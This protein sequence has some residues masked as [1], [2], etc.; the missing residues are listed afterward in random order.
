[1]KRVV[2]VSIG[3][4]KRN[5][6]VKTNMFGEE[7]II[8]R[9][10]T[11][12]DKEKAINLIKEL[13]G[14]VD[15]FG[16]GGIDIYLVCKDKKY[17][18][19]DSTPLKEAAVKTPIVDGSSLKNTLERRVIEY[20]NKNN[21]V[22]LKNA[23]IL[24]TSALDRFGMA[25]AFEKVGSIVTYGDVMFTLGIPVKIKSYNTLYNIAKILAPIATKLPFEMLYPTGK[26]QEVIKE[27]KFEK[28]YQEADIIAGDFLY[29]NRYMPSDMKGK[30][31]ITNTVTANDIQEMKRKGVKLLITTTPEFEGR[32]FGT[33]VMEATIVALLGKYPEELTDKEYNRALDMFDFRPRIEYLNEEEQVL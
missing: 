5:H 27:D 21:I 17:I 14:K 31:I 8:E 28:Y 1:M 9:I 10:G 32:S 15:A 3:S 11:D 7:F 30:T 4:S 26:K 2:S 20:I 29:I 18:I 16:M 22:K 6:K 23:N 19:K 13:D 25:E 12:G 33:N 24:L